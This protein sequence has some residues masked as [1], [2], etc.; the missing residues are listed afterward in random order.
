[1]DGL[2]ARFREVPGMRAFSARG[3]IISSNDGGSRSINLDIS[4]AV[5]LGTLYAV[6]ERAFARAE[7]LFEGARVGSDPGSLSLDQ[8]LLEVRPR[9]ERLAEV[10]LDGA[11]FGYAVAALTDGAF[12]DELIV[13]DDKVDVFLYSSA[14]NEQQLERLADLPIA[15]PSGAVLPLS[16]LAELRETVDS[17][18]IR[19]LDGRRTVTVSIV[20]PRTVALETGVERVREELVEAM[21]LAGEI[22]PG[23]SMR[24]SG[25]SDQLGA[26][27]A[28]MSGN[29]VIA[30]LLSYL[31]L[32]AIFRHWG[33]PLIVMVT[34]PLGM[35]GGVLGLSLLNGFG[36]LAGFSQPF[37][38]IT[39]LGFLVLLGTVVNNPILIVDETRKRLAEGLADVEAAVAEA[40]R[41][42]LRPILMSTLT[43][44]FGLAPLVLIPGAG[45][46]LYRGLGAIVLGG[47]AFST[48]ITLSFLPCLLVEVLRWRRG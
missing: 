44:L 10:G 31:L 48:L 22:P 28:A 20:P 11:S 35:A 23:V 29:F 25:A 19:R 24:I 39:L 17:G 3:S 33:W 12:V 47:I 15:T 27:R 7:A 18:G 6:A 8:P 4:G 16:A 41:S 5:D 43:T 38:M 2:D 37:D 21:R 14:G 46:E 45:T 30:V 13:G 32:V 36:W 9:W 34:V 40:V 26:T 1:M 42:R